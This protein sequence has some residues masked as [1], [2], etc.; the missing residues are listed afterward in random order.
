MSVYFI[1]E[2]QEYTVRNVEKVKWIYHILISA[3]M[4]YRK[5]RSISSNGYILKF[6]IRN[7]A[8]Y[9]NSLRPTKSLTDLFKKLQF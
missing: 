5:Y 7:H 6:A 8:W 2:K 1:K 4:K 9:L 3:G